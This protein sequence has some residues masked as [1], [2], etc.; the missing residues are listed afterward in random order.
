MLEKEELMS[1]L[2]SNMLYSN[3]L[4]VDVLM[5]LPHRLLSDSES[6]N[7]GF[8][9]KGSSFALFTVGTAMLSIPPAKQRM[10]STV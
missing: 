9:T 3:L 1:F 5:L 4:G 2:R 6:A 8:M 10:R 7:F